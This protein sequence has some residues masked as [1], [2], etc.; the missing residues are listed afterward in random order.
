[1]YVLV[2]YFNTC[3]MKERKMG[4]YTVRH[5]NVLEISVLCSLRQ[6]LLDEK[7]GKNSII[8]TILINVIFSCDG[9]L[10]FQ[11]QL[12]QYSV[13]YDPLEINYSK[14]IHPSIHTIG[15]HVPIEEIFEEAYLKQQQSCDIT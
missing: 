11:Q 15:V 4:I 9:K 13:S 8:V 7:H 2:Y 5:F 10:D 3:R 14:N 1:M 6:H 12:L